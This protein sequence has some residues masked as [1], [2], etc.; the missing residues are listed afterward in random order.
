VRS[1]VVRER[2]HAFYQREGFV[3]IKTQRVFEKP[4]GR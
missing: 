3:L 1:N 4:L 2:A